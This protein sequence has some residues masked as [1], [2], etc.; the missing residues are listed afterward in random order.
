MSEDYYQGWPLTTFIRW[1]RYLA[2]TISLGLTG[3]YVAVLSFN[4]DALPTTLTL[5]LA[6]EAK[7]PAPTPG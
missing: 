5:R 2:T 7:A 4:H 6:G 3:F 1:V